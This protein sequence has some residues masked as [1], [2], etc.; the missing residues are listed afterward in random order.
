LQN[1][2]IEDLQGKIV[3]LE[4]HIEQMRRFR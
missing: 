3:S 1:K 2:I 4:E